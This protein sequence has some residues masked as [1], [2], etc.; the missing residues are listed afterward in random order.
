MR[1]AL[2]ALLLTILPLLAQAAPVEQLKMLSEHPVEG[3]RGG[4]LSGLALC[5]DRLWTESDR[6]DDLIYRLDTRD[7]VWQAEN[8]AIEAPP[9][10]DTGLP[11]MLRA[12]AKAA[13][14]IR[15]G[16]LDF[17]GIT[18]DAKGN[19]Y[20]VSEGYAAVL[21]VPVD[22][23]P[24]W[25]KIDPAVIREAHAKGMLRQFNAIFEGVAINAEGDH[26]WLAAE[27]Q[28]RG[29]LSVYKQPGEGWG[30]HGNCILLNESGDEMQPA[31]LPGAHEV[32]RDFADLA[33]YHGKLYTLERN[34]YQIC[35]R[36][37]QTAQVEH[38]WSFAD[39]ALIPSRQYSQKYGLAEA[40]VIDDT[41]AWVGIDNNDGARADGE[42]RPI[43]WRFSAP[44]GGWDVTP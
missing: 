16:V 31:Q 7:T 30:C 22:G 23:Q 25:L 20:L 24:S 14:V 34:I 5:G 42:K 35:R 9:V 6:D 33:L 17:E 1:Y 3:M 15:G 38:C 40:L 41:G 29:L 44:A 2:A 18:C 12:T 32:A 4:N 28:N 43:V 19:R 26:L 8:V 13:S 10:P 11:L 27:R 37:L 21:K 39:E 36:D